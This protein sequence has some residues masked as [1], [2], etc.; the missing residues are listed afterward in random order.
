MPKY[1]NILGL[2]SIVIIVAMCLIIIP[3]TQVYAGEQV[4]WKTFNE[5]NGLF[6]IKYPSNWIPQ[7]M[8]EYE[9]VVI[10]SPIAMN[11]IY[12]GS[13]SSGAIITITADESIYTNVTDSIDSIYA[14]G[15]SLSKYKL[16]EPMECGKYM[17][18]G[19]NACSTVLS[20]KNVGLPGKPIVNE[21]DVV[22]ID[23]DGVQ[24]VIG[25][26]ATK[27]SFDDL[28]PVAQEMIKSFNVTGSVL[29]S[30]DES[31][32]TTGNSPELPPLTESPTVKKL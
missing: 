13:G 25:Y 21:L 19:I 20:Y 2:V 23:E 15:Q 27:D 32:S 8:G 9:G 14:Y 11:F 4:K 26:I 30:E 10:T 29:P 24:Y 22:T 16:L 28:L 6:T 31:A 3:G 5:K 7:K 17:I 12:S 1:G 18:N